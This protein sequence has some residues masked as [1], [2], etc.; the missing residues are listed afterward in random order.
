MVM[1]RFPKMES[2]RRCLTEK[3]MR[4]DVRMCYKKRLENER[5][6]AKGILDQGGE[7]TAAIG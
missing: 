3:R 7:A 2:E 6:A 4:W 1:T 5:E